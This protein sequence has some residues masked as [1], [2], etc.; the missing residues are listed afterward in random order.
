MAAPKPDPESLD[1]RRRRLRYRAFHRG[2]RELDLILGAYV[3]ACVDQ[4][5]LDRIRRLETLLEYP[6]TNLQHWLISADPAPEHVDRELLED[7]RTFQRERTR[8]MRKG[9][10]I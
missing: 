4:L 10:A 5:E 6:E 3:D 8:A 7:I 9:K 2:T 1:A